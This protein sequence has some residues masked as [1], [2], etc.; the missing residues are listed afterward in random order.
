MHLGCGRGARDTRR[1]GARLAN[2][3]ELAAA[4][5]L[6][7]RSS[8]YRLALA[9]SLGSNQ[10]APTAGEADARPRRSTTSK[11]LQ[12]MRCTAAIPTASTSWS[13]CLGALVC[14]SG[15]VVTPR[16]VA[17]AR[18]PPRRESR[19]QLQLHITPDLRRLLAVFVAARRGAPSP[20]THVMIEGVPNAS[21]CARAVHPDGGTPCPS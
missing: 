12:Q 18:A 13:I 15:T 3:L 20:I 6:F 9:S 7:S 4:S 19:A 14:R 2:S 11:I 1:D 5:G 10:A 16:F 8:R 17:D 21:N